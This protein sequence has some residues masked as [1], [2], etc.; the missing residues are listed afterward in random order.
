M[1]KV[2]VSGLMVI[3]P[4]FAL[5]ASVN[6]EYWTSLLRSVGT[7]INMLVG[8]LI[9]LAVVWF[10]WNVFGYIRAANEEKKAE[11]AKGMLWGIIGLAVIVSV[12][13]LVNLL[14]YTFNVGS[15]PAADTTNLLPTSLQ[16]N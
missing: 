14:Q 9:A 1:K 6:T 15:V 3:A 11:A 5:A 4:S 2:I 8:L 7:I 13:G 16:R 10:I 12:W